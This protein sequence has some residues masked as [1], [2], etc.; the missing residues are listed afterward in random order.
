MPEQKSEK[1]DK[2]SNF[3]E[4]L[5]LE[6]HPSFEENE[7][8]NENFLEEIIL[9]EES[10][11]LACDSILKFSSSLICAECLEHE[12]DILSKMINLSHSPKTIFVN[13][14][15]DLDHSSD[16]ATEDEDE[17]EDEEEEIFEEEIS[18]EDFSYD[19]KIKSTLHSLLNEE[20]E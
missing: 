12:S 7:G 6:E 4:K 11:C 1:N 20:D 18:E 5:P 15:A 13:P 9:I 14:D 17:D 10:Y 16:I 2:D 8:S 3:E 19:E